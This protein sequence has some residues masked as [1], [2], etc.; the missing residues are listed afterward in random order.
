[1]PERS[2]S[3][4]L[5]PI[6][7]G[8]L[9]FDYRLDFFHAYFDAYASVAAT[10]TTPKGPVEM[11]LL[12]MPGFGF[13]SV[14]G[15]FAHQ[16]YAGLPVTITVTGRNGDS[17]S[18]IWGA[19]VLQN[20]SLPVNVFEPCVRAENW[21]VAPIFEGISSLSNVGEP[22]HGLSATYD[23]DLLESGIGVSLREAVYQT[24]AS[25]GGTVSVDWTYTGFH[26]Y[27]EAFAHLT[28][29]AGSQDVSAYSASVSGVFQASGST[30][31][32]V[33]PG[34]A[35]GFRA[36]GANYDS[37]SVLFGVVTISNL[38]TP[39]CTADLDCDGEVSG[40]DLAIL[41]GSWGVCEGCSA[42]VDDDGDVDGADLAT[43]LGGWGGCG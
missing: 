12:A 11:P 17:N 1:V 42:D 38:Y 43:L 30:E 31:F 28:F 20:A 15:S 14:T 2:A 34:E 29:F 33:L 7:D 6:V 40:A 23:V 25:A 24:T 27:Y 32:D 22:V 8:E 35:W 21:T 36:G 9:S 18:E 41:L 26:A 4:T 16:V 39:T 10:V 5:I 3:Y 19:F 37:Y 13:A